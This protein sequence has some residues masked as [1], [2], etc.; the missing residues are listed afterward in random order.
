VGTNIDISK[1][2]FKKMSDET[3]IDE[4]FL[5][6]SINNFLT[7]SFLSVA[8]K[9]EKAET[10]DEIRNAYENALG[11]VELEEKALYKW[12]EKAKTVEELMEIYNIVGN[13]I[14]LKLMIDVIAKLISLFP[15]RTE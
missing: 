7:L 1:I 9:I 8:D 5:L 14:N 3:G 4:E 15:K 12:L 10:I 11:I 13:D 2:D 6:N